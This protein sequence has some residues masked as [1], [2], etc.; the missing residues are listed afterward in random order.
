MQTPW[1]RNLQSRRVPRPTDAVLQRRFL[2]K[3]FAGSTDLRNPLNPRDLTTTVY[4]KVR[5]H[6]LPKVLVRLRFCHGYGSCRRGAFAWLLAI[7]LLCA[8]VLCAQANPS[9]KMNGKSIADIRFEGRNADS[10][11]PLMEYLTVKTGKPL[12]IA[13]VS[14]SI[15]ALFGTGK[16]SNIEAIADE[17]ADGRVALTFKVEE[18]YFV[19]EIALSGRQ[20]GPPSLRQLLN[21]T[22]LELGR[23][24]SEVDVKR[25]IEQ[26]TR[27]MEDNGYYGSKFSFT[28]TPHEKS[29]QM[30]VTF[31]L[32][33]GLL[34]RVGKVEVSGNAGFS[35]EEIQQITKIKSGARVV[36]AH[37][38]RAL[39]RLRK[40]YQKG[41]R[42]EAQVSLSRH[43]FH[44][45]TNTVDYL[46]T[47]DR[48]M[49]VNIEV[50]GAKLRQ[51]QIKRYIPVYEENAADDDL[52]NEGTRN[53]RDYF[54]S[55]GYFD[56][57]VSYA[58]DRDP[59]SDRLKIV[60]S[61]EPGERHKLE[62]VHVEGNKY[63]PTETIKERLSVL[64]A[65]Y[66]N[67]NGKFSQTMLT[68]DTQAITALYKTNGFQD[69]SVKAQVEDDYQGHHGWLLILFHIDEGQQSRVHKLTMLGNLAIT[70]NDLS[71]QLSVTE[72]QPFSD[73]AISADRD[74]VVSYYYNRGFPNMDMQITT[75]PFD[76]DK[77]SM[78][79]TYSIREGT[80]EFVDRVYASGLHYTRPH[81]VQKRLRIH[82]GDPLG[83]V[84]MLDSQRRL[85]DLGLF[86]EVNVA[87]QN[88]DG[89]AERKNVL[90]QLTEAK[91]WTFDYGVGFEVSTGS[92]NAGTA[93]S[94]TKALTPEGPTG[95]SPRLSFE[96]TRLNFG[97]RDHTVVM[98][99]RYGRLEQR[100]LISY[101]A[102]RLFAKENWR[103]TVSAF[104]DKSADVRTFTAERLEGSIQAEDVVNKV[105]TLLYR[106][107]YRRVNVDP[108]T[109]AIDPALIP[110]YSQPARI[111]MPSITIVRDKRDDP[112]DAHKGNYT[113][114]DLGVAGSF[115][116]SDSNFGRVLLQN[117]S[118][119]Q[120]GAKKYVFARSTRIGLEIPFN[121][122]QIVPLP[123]RFYAGGGN[124]LRGFSINQA[125][126]RDQLT[127]FPVGGNAL[128]VNNLELRLP[129]PTLPYVDDNLSFVLF[130]D[131]GNVFDTTNHLFKGVFRLH[132]ASIAACSQPGTQVPCNYNFLE[133]AVG[134]GVRY[135]T[136][137]GPVRFDLG[138]AFN[139]ARY[140]ILNDGATSSTQ[141]INVFFS[142]GQTF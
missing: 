92:G 141:R 90:F 31:Q 112:I 28:L 94:G 119:Y 137:V 130:H 13:K 11:D 100:G 89:L 136:P 10:S 79:V 29:R 91:R 20:K 131:M 65:S 16:F 12:D 126:P 4:Y 111:G 122:S 52:L 6:D 108:T 125:G 56:V 46:F 105:L 69:V 22:K 17:T 115:F 48:G 124:S 70:S 67:V 21:A 43:N 110:L 113:T 107:S 80:R 121:D 127:G 117:S 53:L 102:P 8:P 142:I 30:N 57:K 106:F 35:A 68:R 23:P 140:P 62:A 120:F 33:P 95:W 118:Y 51:G 25:A 41:D 123:E 88:P 66:L 5:N 87:V 116:G 86:S 134:L 83:Q 61:V 2:K 97:G 75:L 76:G 49:K 132:Q 39:E 54:Q 96:L 24:Y 133:Q 19:G 36:D 26:M 84:D 78:D 55:Q 114:A 50:E 58:R 40:K 99:A 32:R 138:Y 37:A 27:V 63:F 128:F 9:S 64:P 14:S 42:L 77:H 103:L 104:Y 38:T 73:Y 72:G 1:L 81:V 60:Y 15:K 45:E 44:P 7:A 3:V 82:D 74:A 34:A 71:P 109:L 139:P 101:E 47:V 59:A 85:Y 18:K 93:S 135:H 129:P 98:K